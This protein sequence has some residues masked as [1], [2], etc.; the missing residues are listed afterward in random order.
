MILLA[1]IIKHYLFGQA[2]HLE[3]IYFNGQL[4]FYGRTLENLYNHLMLLLLFFPRMRVYFI[5]LG[6]FTPN[7]CDS[8]K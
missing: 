2:L 6:I 5:M 7:N 4:A 8:K 1:R 3:Y